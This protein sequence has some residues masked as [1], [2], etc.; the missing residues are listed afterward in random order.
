[1]LADRVQA[2]LAR[3]GGTGVEER[4][5]IDTWYSDFLQPALNQFGGIQ[6]LNMTSPGMRVTEIMATLP[7][8]AAALRRC[9]PAFAAEMVRAL[10]LS[11]ARFTF[12][13]RP[14]AGGPRKTFGNRDLSLLERPWPN[15]TTGE[16]ITKME[17][18]AGLAGN[19][20]V[21]NRTAGRLRVLRPD[22]TAIV[23]G[24]EQEPQDAA[25]AL[26]GEVV[27][28]VYANG[29]LTAPGNGAVA[30]MFHRVQTL[31]PDEVAH[32]SPMPDPEGGGIGMSWLTPAIRD[33]QGDQAATEHK[34]Q[35]WKNGAS[36]NLVVK[37]IPAMT[38]GQFDEIVD[39]IESNHTGVRNA[40]K[41]LYLTAGADATV[42]GSNWQQ[43]DLKAIMG[44][45]ET[46]ISYLSR[47]PASVLGI[48]EGLAGSS[49]NA[50]N[51]GMARRIMAD[52]WIYPTLQDLAASLASVTKVP[53]DAELWYLTDDMPI[54][55]E[56][57]KDAAEIE[58]IKQA[59]IVAYVNAGFTPESSVEA[60][61][62][63][64][65]SRL[66]HTGNLS[67][68][69]QPPGMV[70]SQPTDTSAPVAPTDPG[71]A[72]RK[73]APPVKSAKPAPAKG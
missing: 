48:S 43:M 32:W 5:S 28:Y 71:A 29:G 73:P 55:R 67:V 37:G 50:G 9:P 59:S 19:A 24:S 69:L 68:Q 52:T 33:M 56:D 65:V 39:M 64:D 26:D 70:A 7:S 22:W 36:P 16:L 2:R 62:T 11:Q 38:K 46:R 23:Y 47:V 58:Q 30:G 6:G 35:F 13:S 61:Q 4:N 14:S 1:V 12:R 17:W 27:G 21:T 20:Y 53:N 18:H 49:L 66:K 51:F 54:L 45:G 8:Y 44:A 57:S 41:T 34:L 15:G 42:V 40:F 31:L 25:T 10:V 63:G 3:R 60:V 72:P